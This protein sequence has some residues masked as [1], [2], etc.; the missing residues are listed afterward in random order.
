MAYEIARNALYDYPGTAL[1]Y[2]L[3]LAREVFMRSIF[4]LGVGWEGGGGQLY[5]EMKSRH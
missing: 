4:S 1:F 5:G 3:S 2:W